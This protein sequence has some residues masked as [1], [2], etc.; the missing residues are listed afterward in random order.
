[1]NQAKREITG[2]VGLLFPTDYVKACDLHSKDVT[3]AIDHL[4]METLQTQGGRKEDKPVIYLR[5]ITKDGTPGKLLGKRLVMNKTN[6][7]SIVKVAGS[8]DVSKW[9]GV[10]ITLYP[11]ECRGA[12]GSQVECIRVRVR[13]NANAAEIPDDMSAAPAPRPEFVDEANDAGETPAS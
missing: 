3:V 2:H 9:K 13:T 4:E 5:A 10:K 6:G 11:S 1:M 7:K 12:D 8:P